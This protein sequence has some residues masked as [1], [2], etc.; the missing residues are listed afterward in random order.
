[1]WRSQECFAIILLDIKRRLLRLQVVTIGTATE[2]LA[3][4]HDVFR[5]VIHREATRI[6]PM[7]RATSRLSP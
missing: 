7:A 4:P 1:M 3:H 5:A 2:T 6:I